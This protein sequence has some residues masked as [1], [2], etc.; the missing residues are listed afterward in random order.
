MPWTLTSQNIW[1]V[2]YAIVVPLASTLPYFAKRVRSSWKY[3]R[4]NGGLVFSYARL[5]VPCTL[6][7]LCEHVPMPCGGS[8]V[9][10]N[11]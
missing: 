10:Y 7:Q 1:D 4:V 5:N 6:P 8:R 3:E 11:V 2:S 9:L